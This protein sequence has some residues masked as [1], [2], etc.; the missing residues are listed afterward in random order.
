[1]LNT[2]LAPWPFYDTDEINAATSCLTSG[3]VNQWTGT[4]VNLFEREFAE[5]VGTD[6]AV[7]VMNGTVALDLILKA[8]IDSRRLFPGDEVIVTSRTFLAS[9]SSIINYDLVPIFADVDRDSGNITVESISEKITRRTK[10]IVC[11]HLAGWP[12]DMVEIMKLANRLDLFV[13]EDCAQAH[14]ADID[15]KKVG[16]FG[17]ASAWSFCQDKIMSTGGEGGM[18][19]TN[20]EWLSKHIWSIKDHG[21]SYDK[22]IGNKYQHPPGFRWVH[23]SFGSN[24]RM[25]EFQAAI[26]RAQLKK[27]DDWVDRRNAIAHGLDVVATEYSAV[28]VATSPIGVRHAKYKHYLYVRSNGLNPGWS[29]DVIIK[30]LNDL[31]TP[32]YP[33]SCSEV[34][35]EEAFERFSPNYIPVERLWVAKELGDTS[36]MFLV[37]P[38]ITS[39]QQHEMYSNLALVLQR[40]SKVCRI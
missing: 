40:A 37:H 38:N 10:A 30:E 23:D 5:Y 35:R 1:M 34:Y 16:S 17:H 32:C 25:T 21:K 31:G 18:I 15:D 6:Y 29:R 3:M 12:C 24:Y 4:Q 26:G 33:G 7:A 19:T 36:L 28:R 11:V 20:N 8:A 14:G 2:N 27:L 39:S 22:T 9:V 13:I